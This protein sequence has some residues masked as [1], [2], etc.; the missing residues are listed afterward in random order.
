MVRVR[1]GHRGHARH[2]L[3]HSCGWRSMSTAACTGEHGLIACC[4]EK[5]NWPVIKSPLPN[6]QAVERELDSIKR[7]PWLGYSARQAT[8][9]LEEAQAGAAGMAGG[10]DGNLQTLTGAG[11][12]GAAAAGRGN[13]GS[14]TV[15]SGS[16]QGAVAVT[17]AR[18]GAGAGA[19]AAM[20]GAAGREG[21]KQAVRAGSTE[22]VGV[23]AAGGA[24]PM[25]GNC[26]ADGGQGR[27]VLA[28]R[29]GWDVR[30]TAGSEGGDAEYTARGQSAAGGDGSD[31]RAA[32]HAERRGWDSSDPEG[33]SKAAL[34]LLRMQHEGE[35]GRSGENSEDAYMFILGRG[36]GT[37]PAS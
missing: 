15:G 37:L 36:R 20:G 3:E 21:S 13:L 6:L 28:V 19:G 1:S 33:D 32:A 12:M 31:L 7:N 35:V 27:T 4:R 18:T 23:E 5:L 16:I 30:P 29:R 22:P 25:A 9:L 8:T 14:V 26:T 17:G 24:Q 2:A 10:R 11:T 34:P